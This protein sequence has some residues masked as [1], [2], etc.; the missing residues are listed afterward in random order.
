MK[1]IV[2]I[3]LSVMMIL[4]LF[5]AVISAADDVGFTMDENEEG[6]TMSDNG[7]LGSEYYYE[8][9]KLLDRLPHTFEMWVKPADVEENGVVIGNFHYA[10]G[11]EAAICLAVNSGFV[12]R[13]GLDT[14]S[15]KGYA[16][17]F[18]NAVLTANEWS[19]VAFVYD[20][21]AMKIHCYVNGVLKE[22][23]TAKEKLPQAA[24]EHFPFT[25]GGDHRT[26]NEKYFKGGIGNISFYSD[27][28]TAAEIASDYSN[29]V[30]LNDENIILH[31]ELDSKDTQ[32]AFIKDETGNG[33]D[34]YGYKMWLTEE[35]M[36]ELRGDTSNRA[37]SFAVVGDPQYM[38]SKV[39][40]PGVIYD[41]IVDN[42]ESKNI[43]YVLGVGDITD[44]NLIADWD[45][46]KEAITKM[47]GV[48]EYSLIRGNHDF[49]RGDSNDQFNLHFA[50]H[51]PYT[52]QFDNYGGYYIDGSVE[53][54]YR[55][56]SIGETDWL[57][58]NLDYD[59]S[60][61][62]LTWACSV[63]EEHPNHK[64]V[65]STHAYMY[66]DGSRYDFGDMIYEDGSSFDYNWSASNLGD[67]L[68]KKVAS[69]YENVQ[70][71]LS[72]HVVSDQ[73]RVLQSKGVHGNTVTQMLIDGQA[74]DSK[75]KDA[76]GAGL[77]AILYFDEAGE[78]IS[79]EYYSTVKG[80]YFKTENQ[81]DI[82]LTATVEEENTAWDGKAVEAPE[83][84]GTKDDPYIIS[85]AANLMWM[86]RAIGMGAST[87]TV[88]SNPF[89]DKYFK[90]VCD[91]DL[92]GHILPSIGYFFNTSSNMFVFG[93]TY[94]GG[95]Y[96]IKNGSIKNASAS[97]THNAY[98]GTGLFGTI[99]GAKIKNIVMDDI[100][101]SDYAAY[102]M[103]VG[104]AVSDSSHDASF[105][106]VENCTVKDSCTILST[107]NTRSTLGNYAWNSGL[108]M[109][110]G[111]IVGMGGNI[112][113]RGCVNEANVTIAGNHTFYGGIM[114]M[115][116]RNVEIVSCKNTGDI[117]LDFSISG[118][119]RY[120]KLYHINGG[121][122]GSVAGVEDGSTA[123]ITYISDN[124]WISN[125][126]NEGD[127]VL[128]GTKT[129]TVYYGGILGLS[130]QLKPNTEHYVINCSSSGTATKTDYVGA[131]V[132]CA[133]HD[134]TATNKTASAL[135]ISNCTN[136][137][138]LAEY[139]STSVNDG[140]LSPL[141]KHSFGEWTTVDD[142]AHSATC[143]CGCG[144]VV[145]ISHSWNEGVEIAAGQIKYTCS[146]CSATKTVSTVIAK[147]GNKSY[148]SLDEAIAAVKNNETI[149]VYSDVTISNFRVNA[150]KYTI[151]GQNRVKLTVST[152]SSIISFSGVDVTFEN[153]IVESAN[154]FTTGEGASDAIGTMTFNNCD[155]T[156]GN[157]F[158][159]L[160]GSTVNIND[161]T[162]KNTHSAGPMFYMRNNRSGHNGILNITDSH[163]TYAGSG[164]AG[165]ACL[166][167]FNASYAHT[168]NIYGNSIIETNGR[169]ARLNHIA[170]NAKAANSGTINMDDS[171]IL[172]LNPVNPTDSSSYFLAGAASKELI[173]TGNPTYKTNSLV[174][175]KGFKFFY[176]SN[177]IVKDK[178]GTFVGYKGI[179]DSG[180]DILLSGV[181][182]AGVLAEGFSVKPVY[183]TAA[184]FDMIDGASLRTVKDENGIRFSTT[185]S[186]TLADAVEGKAVFGTLISPTK[187]LGSNELTLENAATLNAT[188]ADSVLNV[189]STRYAEG[190]TVNTYHAAII[191]PDE[192]VSEKAIYTLELAARGY[193]TISYDDGT[194]ATFYTDFDTENIRSMLK[195][196]EILDKTGEY[197]NNS[198]VQSI[199]EACK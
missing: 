81:F 51:S 86:S 68:W 66:N 173:I 113:I 144:T 76:G 128:K 67:N 114:G 184:D 23:Q 165:N 33:Y 35:E 170:Y 92:N 38:V 124:L 188:T 182:A 9:N 2:A 11:Y 98:W 153:L 148:S 112:T 147:I 37:Y 73:I 13:F 164:A 88:L 55:T 47:D 134:A 183:M 1:K 143:S 138:I 163:L 178:N 45:L 161:S 30:N 12:P 44:T 159:F 168:V 90:Q 116:K 197:D 126:H 78:N 5:T 10:S 194:E 75:L 139:N 52:N 16:Y 109:H 167:H 172:Y 93:G 28:R 104:N 199:I 19:H 94:D 17:T 193:M 70:M 122:L 156:I 154:G 115:A 57:F 65:I 6:F 141:V 50:T 22:T 196:A 25:I 198:V 31:Y 100:T 26:L 59:P 64:V 63:I 176:D 110:V 91:I 96:A 127:F 7:S 191:M 3:L 166:F 56:M 181:V 123:T 87:S 20:D 99:Y 140:A 89:K 97:H 48:V 80:M 36:A 119:T 158:R 83:G 160:G 32:S 14:E 118:I 103:I 72:G 101:I 152:G 15:N 151:K 82:D 171:V 155:I 174:A 175:Q 146:D 177:I 102:G 42:V 53:N 132:G 107:T 190:E 34:Q 117:V 145:K 24:I 4:P 106:L 49:N 18:K 133:T 58:L 150:T 180:K 111:A 71:V 105:N 189:V 149:L 131:I 62:I 84:F 136:N 108:P 169:G 8:P 85:S 74:L 54:T 69:R 46:A 43:K 186:K 125:C 95:G 29:G 120:S 142:D 77:V 195:V 41:W 27:V 157:D 121:I 21:S 137:S 179:S 61:A 162:M 192:G 129:G 39:K 185:Y 130:S 187:L 79:V 135:V 60:N 40:N